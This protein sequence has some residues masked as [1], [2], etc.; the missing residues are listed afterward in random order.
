MTKVVRFDKKISDRPAHA[1]DDNV[2]SMEDIQITPEMIEAGIEALVGS[3]GPLSPGDDRESTVVRIFE[4]MRR[5]EPKR[6]AV[7]PNTNANPRSEDHRDNS[8]VRR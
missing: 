2:P 3:I 6:G 5:L 8:L 1:R 4:R 7:R